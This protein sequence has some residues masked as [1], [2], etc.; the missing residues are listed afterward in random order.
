ML[1]IYR[2]I[3]IIALVLLVPTALYAQGQARKID[4]MGQIRNAEICSRLDSLAFQLQA[5]PD[6]RAYIIFYGGRKYLQFFYD[7]KKQDIVSK[8]VPAKRGEAQLRLLKWDDY[9]TFFRKIE[10]SRFEIINGG[11][12]EKFTVEFWLVPK[13]AKPPIPTP[14]L[15]EKD[16]KFGKGR[17]KNVIF[18]QPNC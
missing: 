5:N 8:E 13:G 10:K 4:E 9:L 3:S 16:I 1:F 17:P 14:T 18:S 11:Y 7:R 2:N 6:D 12:R 15:T